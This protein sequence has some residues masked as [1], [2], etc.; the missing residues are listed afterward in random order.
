MDYTKLETT[1]NF[2]SGKSPGPSPFAPDTFIDR[3]FNTVQTSDI[4]F[5]VF[6]FCLILF[7]ICV[8][9]VALAK[10]KFIRTSNG[11]IA[12]VIKKIHN[13]KAFYCSFA[14]I[15]ISFVV[16]A[17]APILNK[18]VASNNIISPKNIN[19]YVA[20]DG[21]LKFDKIS[22]SSKSG[23]NLKFNGI[24]AELC[25][26]IS[27]LDSSKLNI[28][29]EDNLFY[30]DVVPGKSS[31][32][33]K[34]NS[35][36]DMNILLNN[37]SEKKA[38]ELI[39]KAVIK[40]KYNVKELEDYEVVFN[41]NNQEKSWSVKVREDDKVQRPK[42]PVYPY[43]NFVE[44]QKNGTKYDFDQSVVNNFELVA[45]W[46]DAKI[47]KKPTWKSNLIYN[48]SFQ[49]SDN[50]ALWDGYDKGKMTISGDIT[51]DIA[52]DYQARFSLLKGC[53]WEDGTTDDI[54]VK[55]GISKR[56]ISFTG[57][58]KSV[59]YTGDTISISDIDV[60]GLVDSHSH[61]ANYKATGVNVGNYDGEIS[62][63]ESIHIYDLEEV[64]VSSNYN[65]SSSAGKLSITPCSLTWSI[66]LAPY[67]EEYDG[68]AHYNCNKPE[69]S[70]K[71]G[72]TKFLYSFSQDS[73]YTDDISSLKKTDVADNP[74][75]IYVKASNS[76]YSLE[77]KCSSSLNIYKRALVFSGAQS[78]HLPYNGEKQNGFSMIITGLVNGHTHNVE[79][80][81][82]SGIEA[83]KTPYVGKFNTA[84]KD[85]CIKD[86]EEKTVTQNYDISFANPGSIIIDQCDDEW[87]IS[88]Q[89]YTCDYD[90]ASKY[91]K[92]QPTS[93]A[94]TG[95]TTFEYSF[96]NK[97]WKPSLDQLI[98]YDANEGGYTIYV[99]AFNPNYAINALSESKLIIKKR[100]VEFIGKSANLEYDASLHTINE[101]DSS[102]L[103]EGHSD[104]V[105]YDA[106]GLDVGEYTGVITKSADVVIKKDQKICTQNYNIKTTPGLLTITP[107]HEFKVSLESSK[108][109]F[110]NK[111]HFIT[112]KPVSSATRGITT[113]SFS[114]DQTNWVD[115]LESLAKR[116]A[117]TDGYDV[118]VKGHNDQY[119]VQDVISSAKLY[120]MKAKRNIKISKD[121][122]SYIK[123][124][125][126][127]ENNIYND[128]FISTIEPSGISGGIATYDDDEKIITFQKTSESIPDTVEFDTKAAGLKDFQFK[129]SA[130]ESGK[131]SYTVTLSDKN[132][133]DSHATL[134]TDVDNFVYSANSNKTASVVKYVSLHSQDASE[135]FYNVAQSISGKTNSQ[136]EIVTYNVN[137][138]G[139]GS[140]TI[141]GEDE[142][143]PHLRNLNLS[144]NVKYIA[145]GAFKNAKN[146]NRIKA[147]AIETIGNE[148]F[149]NC[150]NLYQLGAAE[151]T[152]FFGDSLK[153][154]GKSAFEN[155]SSKIGL[156]HLRNCFSLESIESRAFYGNTGLSTLFLGP[157]LKYIKAEAFDKTSLQYDEMGLIRDS[158]GI[159]IIKAN[160]EIFKNEVLEIGGTDIDTQII[161]DGAFA[162]NPYI[163]KI[164]ILKNQIY[165]NDY[166]FANCK[167]LEQFVV[168]K[169]QT[170]IEYGYSDINDHVLENCG[171]AVDENKTFI[172]AGCKDN[173]PSSNPALSSHKFQFTNKDITADDKS[174]QADCYY[175]L[176]NDVNISDNNIKVSNQNAS[177][178]DLNG[179]KIDCNFKTRA[180]MIDNQSTLMVVDSSNNHAGQICRANSNKEN[181]G[182]FEIANG[183]LLFYSGNVLN[184]MSGGNG[185][186]VNMT[187]EKNT[188]KTFE[189]ASFSNCI[190]GHTFPNW[191]KDGGAVYADENSD[192]YINGSSFASCYAK[193][194]GAIFTKG[195]CE[196][197]NASFTKCRAS[198]N[199]CGGAMY[200]AG[201]NC[202][203]NNS[204]FEENVTTM[205]KKGGAVY[206][207]IAVGF[208]G[209][210]RCCFY[211][212]WCKEEW[213]S[214]EPQSCGALYSENGGS[215]IILTDCKGQQAIG[216]G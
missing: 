135:T 88:L 173:L 119:T 15:A 160:Q 154:I 178:V 28:K 125:D 159:A 196:V 181:G 76:N 213:K 1:I 191:V 164:L 78:M 216:H 211:N 35:T 140:H 190:A 188:L 144:T 89:D 158:L 93:Y 210:N 175:C 167:N 86:A 79:Y 207:N 92:N 161:A 96:D 169:E 99:R 41:P 11:F 73:G 201:T 67:E 100:D 180:F 171:S 38:K 59:V 43:H 34:T 163:K 87:K 110:D 64:D 150:N 156:L 138:L 107:Q 146:L 83:S 193:N 114:F 177:V 206:V 23:K 128:Q 153:Y 3:A 30:D 179:H 195:S 75:A 24:E 132:F 176:N 149:L 112:N 105:K 172:I 148:A 65:I 25:S 58:S 202:H 71:S 66:S 63:P 116:D 85:V 53:C 9:V 22:I 113:F 182:A 157:G 26:G 130:I 108:F 21:K 121:H 16:I 51:K 48:G 199:G 77:A 162:N 118:Y 129:S 19:A 5:S 42:D 18:A 174:L 14:I 40:L 103:I 106:S 101:Y 2:I 136:L 111:D 57:I 117:N 212:N 200:Y 194:G 72:E 123:K 168:K 17:Y 141:F 4:F 124:D 142:K 127:I 68:Y 151:E 44:W 115:N 52:G 69:S 152:I 94:K 45:K 95:I 139:D 122:L 31:I 197:N 54:Q 183:T 133:E 97:N 60:V 137:T 50:V 203:I 6:M 185:G 29:I 165:I 120:I 12:K 33:F 166:A 91:N 36:V 27:S 214:V 102:G 155:S 82:P 47:T 74:Y 37:L 186:L 205:N 198:S 20:D 187:K 61:D 84:L 46:S 147:T 7:L 13:I 8:F 32:S 109:V 81:E 104:N 80:T 70:A 126:S 215:H 145:N 208:V 90:D 62:S 192:I 39:G 98:K 209:I 10:T 204:T 170:K 56:D 143:S 55:W 131:L 134:V 184:C 49:S 189:D